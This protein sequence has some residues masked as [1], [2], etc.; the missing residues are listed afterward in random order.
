VC[1]PPALRIMVAPAF[2]GAAG[3]VPL[4]VAAYYFRAIGDFVRCLFLVEDRPGYDAVC[5]WVGAV[6]CGAGYLLLIPKYGIWGAAYATLAAFVL[7]AGLSIV[8]TWRLRPY[9]VEAA[10]LLKVGAACAAAFV[11]YFALSHATLA[12]SIGSATLS[13]VLFPMALW[14]LRFPTPGEW[15][16]ALAAAGRLQ[17]KFLKG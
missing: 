9:H 5:N 3:L 12:V 15:T 13:L 16:L 8:W 14:V 10:R 17:A 2:R 6:I 7:L 1:S 11:P 4:I